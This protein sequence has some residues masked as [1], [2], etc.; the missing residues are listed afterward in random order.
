MV[1]SYKTFNYDLT[2]IP[3]KKM[4]TLSVSKNSEKKNQ[5]KNI[6]TIFT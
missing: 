3:K 1:S 4:P 6:A 2:D 5:L